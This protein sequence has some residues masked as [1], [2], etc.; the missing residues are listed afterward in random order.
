MDLNKIT[1]LGNLT[2][3][4]EAKEVNGSKIVKFG[5][6]T[7][8][9]WKDKKTGNRKEDVVFHNIIAWNGLANTMEKWLKKGDKI[10]I[11]GRVSNRT[12]EKDGVKKNY[13]EVVAKN[14][15]MLSGKSK[16][17]EKSEKEAEVVEEEVDTT[18]VP[19]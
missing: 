10:Y 3:D 13:S 14:L 15:I 6:A 12:Y 4:P 7:N 11:E 9:A 1:L 17:T 5:L 8:Y 19:F 18:K 16:K 2:R